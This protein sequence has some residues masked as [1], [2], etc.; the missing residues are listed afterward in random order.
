MDPLRP[1][2]LNAPRTVAPANSLG[3]PNSGATAAHFDTQNPAQPAWMGARALTECP[4]ISAAV[5]P[6]APP[7]AGLGLNFAGRE[8]DTPPDAERSS[9]T[10]GPE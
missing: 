9:S 4:I 2:L 1:A 3:D 7:T 5:A 10:S 8:K 6:D